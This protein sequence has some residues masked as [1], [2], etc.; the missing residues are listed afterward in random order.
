MTIRARYA[1]TCTVCGKPIK[2]GDTM[3]KGEGL[4]Q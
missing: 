1:S 2:I 3:I 4:V